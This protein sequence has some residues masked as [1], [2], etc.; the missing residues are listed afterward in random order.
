[1][2]ATTPLQGVL[3]GV[4]VT[5]QS[6]LIGWYSVFWMNQQIIA[7]SYAHTLADCLFLEME[8]H[9]QSTLYPHVGAATVD[10][11]VSW[12]S[13]SHETACL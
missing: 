13:V 5:G 3:K 11:G 12:C 9:A 7:A 2:F 10:P 6:D 1:V 4:V 8:V